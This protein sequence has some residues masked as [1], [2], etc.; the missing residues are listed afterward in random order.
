MT[1]NAF[2]YY[3][4]ELGMNGS[5]KDENKRAPMYWSNDPDDPDMCVGP[6]DMDQPV[7]LF[8]SVKEQ[9]GDERSVYSWFREIIRIR[10]SYPAIARGTTEKA[11]SICDDKTAAF[12]RTSEADDDLLIVMNLDGQAVRKEIGRGYKLAETLSTDGEKITYRKKTVNMP[13]YSI[14]VFVHK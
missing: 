14:A 1:G 8:P 4:E 10:N 12:F 9:I 11:D 5:G 13:A 3:G 7:V 6:P 2:V